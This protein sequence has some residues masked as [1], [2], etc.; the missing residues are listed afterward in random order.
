MKQP[1]LVHF[2]MSDQFCQAVR[3]IFVSIQLTDITLHKIGRRD[4]KIPISISAGEPGKIGQTAWQ[5]WL[6]ETKIRS[7]TV[8][9]NGGLKSLKVHAPI[10]YNLINASVSPPARLNFWLLFAS[11]IFL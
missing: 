8:G 11:N 3:L 5:N 2:L 4:R 9:V 6:D 10:F 1:K 7:A